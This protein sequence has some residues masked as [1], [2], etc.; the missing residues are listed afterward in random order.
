MA[1]NPF[2]ELDDVELSKL[3]FDFTTHPYMYYSETYGKSYGTLYSVNKKTFQK[4]Q[5]LFNGDDTNAIGAKDKV[6]ICPGCKLPQFR[7]KE[8]LKSLKA[9]LTREP[10]KATIIVSTEGMCE[11]VENGH[12]DNKQARLSKLYF[13]DTGMFAFKKYDENNNNEDYSDAEAYYNDKLENMNIYKNIENGENITFSSFL[14]DNV[15]WTSALIRKIDNEEYDDNKHYLYPI[16]MKL[17]YEILSKKIPILHENDLC[18][19]ANSGLKLNDSEVFESITMMLKGT[20]QDRRLAEEMIFNSDYSDAEVQIYD[21]SRNYSSLGYS[22]SRNKNRDYF[23]SE[24]NYYLF[25]NMDDYEFITWMHDN[26]KLTNEI[27]NKYF[28][29]FKDECLDELGYNKYNKL[30]SFHIKPKDDWKQYFDDENKEKEYEK[31][32]EETKN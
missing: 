18:S 23:C 29:N 1:F 3:A 26:E 7:I 14:I 25:R 13:K 2:I 12:R 16:T 22:S 24:S 17:I 28:N 27:F 9:T 30:F 21:L 5:Q 32:N 20:S 11:E 10:E 19:V 4:I 6:F 15:S 8:Y 31:I